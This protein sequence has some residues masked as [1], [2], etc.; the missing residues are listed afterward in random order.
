MN[1]ADLFNMPPQPKKVEAPGPFFDTAPQATDA[2]VAR[3]AALPTVTKEDVRRT[4]GEI[5][6]AALGDAPRIVIDSLSMLAD[7][8]PTGRGYTSCLIHVDD[9]GFFEEPL[10]TPEERRQ[11]VADNLIVETVEHDPAEIEKLL[12]AD[13]EHDDV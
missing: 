13:E 11:Y 9:A 8:A 4:L 5:K 3:I 10:N 2:V 1:I 12:D 7:P 6:A